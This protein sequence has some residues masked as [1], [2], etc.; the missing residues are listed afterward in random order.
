MFKKIIAIASTSLILIPWVLAYEEIDCS[1]DWVF[2]TNS[3]SQ[4]FNWWVKKQ[5]DY[6]WLLKD[7]WIN[8]SDS[9]RILYKEEQKMPMMINLN[10]NNVSWSQTPSSDWFW[11]YTQE[12]DSLYSQED[13]WYI[14]ESWKEINWIQSKDWYAYKLDKNTLTQNSNIGLLVYPISS[15]LILDDWTPSMEDVEHR[16]CVLFKSAWASASAQPK[17]LPETWPAE[18]ILLLILAM[19]L[20][21]WIFRVKSKV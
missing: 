13:E 4:C 20:G 7:K 18:Y 12:F 10:S 19:I 15:R 11:E 1:S 21:L 17:R 6:I 2:E 9:S 5:W 14:L 16:E 8:S 3:C